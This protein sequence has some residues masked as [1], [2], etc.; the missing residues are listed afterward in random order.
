[1]TFL[2][3]PGPDAGGQ[4]GC[5]DAPANQGLSARACQHTNTSRPPCAHVRPDIGE[6][7][8]RLV[9]EHDPELARGRVER[10]PVERCRLH[11]GYHEPDVGNTIGGGALAGQ[12]HQRLGNVSSDHFAVRDYL[13]GRSDGTATTTAANIKDRFPALEAGVIE[14]RLGRRCGHRLPMPPRR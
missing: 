14:E 11:I 9:E 3:G 10:P 6:G 4:N 1:M 7:A 8:H 13:T 12:G 5:N 2:P